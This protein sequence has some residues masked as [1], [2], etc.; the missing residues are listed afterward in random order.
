VMGGGRRPIKCLV[1][2]NT[3]DQDGPT[4]PPSQSKRS[5]RATDVWSAPEAAISRLERAAR[6]HKSYSSE[7]V[8]VTLLSS[9]ASGRVPLLPRCTL[10]FR[11]VASLGRTPSAIHA[12]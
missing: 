9:R 4:G 10:H 11:R 7:G 5:W 6:G 2:G 1:A 3:R 8:A 12:Y